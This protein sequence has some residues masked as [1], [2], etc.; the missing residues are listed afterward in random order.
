MYIDNLNM[1][2][3]FVDY[4][5]VCG[6]NIKSGLDPNEVYGELNFEFASDSATD[7]K[8][9]AR[10]VGL[11]IERDRIENIKMRCFIRGLV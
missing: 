4:F 1:I 6:L 3:S 5:V 9:V 10:P 7:F 11:L 2:R 8:R